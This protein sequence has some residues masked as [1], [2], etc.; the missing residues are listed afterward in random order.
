M[1]CISPGKPWSMPANVAGSRRRWH[2]TPMSANVDCRPAPSN[3][4]PSH[5]NCAA[6]PK[7]ATTCCRECSH[8]TL[9]LSLHLPLP[10]LPCLL[11]HP[12]YPPHSPA[13]PHPFS[14]VQ[15]EEAV[16]LFMFAGRPRQ[17]LRILTQRLSDA[18]EGAATDAGRGS[19][20]P[21]NSMCIA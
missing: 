12:S 18:V 17:A 6:K 9:R 4:R 13:H 14:R 5:L 3:S 15:L 1:R 16:E 19:Y 21:C 11:N 10:C 2:P 8:Q 7:P 20:L